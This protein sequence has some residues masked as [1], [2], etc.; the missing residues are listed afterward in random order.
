LRIIAI[1]RGHDA[2]GW[3]VNGAG[4]DGGSVTLL[5]SEDDHARD[6][7]LRDI[8]RDNADLRIIPIAL[9]PEGLRVW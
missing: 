2:A 4:G 5:A 6:A 8:L 3:K 9:S 7:M 1:A